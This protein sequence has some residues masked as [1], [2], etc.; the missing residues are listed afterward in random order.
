MAKHPWARHRQN[1]FER[2]HHRCHYCGVLMWSGP[3][4]QLPGL[5][6][7]RR[8]QCTA[9]H[10]HARCDGGDHSSVNIVAACRHCNQTRHRRQHPPTPE[11]YAALVQQRVRAGRW[12][13]ADVHRAGLIASA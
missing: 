7:P 6:R 3:H 11:R 13:P 8:L 5:G 4:D 1:A 10:L 2:Q 9:E 12:H